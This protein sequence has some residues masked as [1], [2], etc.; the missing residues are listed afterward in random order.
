MRRE[1]RDRNHFKRMRFPPFDD[2][3][4]P[5]D[6]GENILD[7]E[8]MLEPIQ[9]DLDEE[10]DDSIFDWFYDQHILFDNFDDFHGLAVIQTLALRHGIHFAQRILKGYMYFSFS[11]APLRNCKIDGGI[12]IDEVP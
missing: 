9:M 3:E 7:M 4:P 11:F 10:E 2:E 1:K 6:Y 5:L 12:S 8:P